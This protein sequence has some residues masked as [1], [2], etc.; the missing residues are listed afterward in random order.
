[1]VKIQN[2]IVVLDESNHQ[3]RYELLNIH[4]LF[5]VLVLILVDLQSDLLL[6]VTSKIGIAHEIECVVVHTSG[7]CNKVQLDLG[8]VLERDALD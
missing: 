5:T 6:L 4:I 8:F 2:P 1:M 7:G 3:E